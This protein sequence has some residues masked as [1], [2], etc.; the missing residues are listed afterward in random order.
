MLSLIFAGVVVLFGAGHG[1]MLISA[2]AAP[3]GG[4]NGGHKLVE[5]ATHCP[6]TCLLQAKEVN[7]LIQ[8]N[9]DDDEP[10]PATFIGTSSVVDSNSMYA[11]ALSVLL[12]A[13][14]RRRPPDLLASYSILRI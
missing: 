13:F 2:H 5:T 7:Y 3:H 6:S 10:V 9:E 8:A 4:H 12:F 1:P 11:L 14:L